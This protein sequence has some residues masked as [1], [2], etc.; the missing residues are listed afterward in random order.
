M[1][2]TH[3]TSSRHKRS[4]SQKIYRM[5]REY[6]EEQKQLDTAN[7][8][9]Y[10]HS[11]SS[12]EKRQFGQVKKP[13]RAAQVFKKKQKEMQEKKAELVPADLSSWS[14]VSEKEKKEVE[15]NQADQEGEAELTTFVIGVSNRKKSAFE[16]ELS[17]WDF[18]KRC[19]PTFGVE[20]DDRYSENEELPAVKVTFKKRKKGNKK[21]SIA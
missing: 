1:K 11:I 16:N 5:K 4:L 21:K 17:S 15:K 10:C 20:N 19:E 13:K 9:L 6:K 3:E 2:K 12:R 8:E 18:S 14:V 7:K